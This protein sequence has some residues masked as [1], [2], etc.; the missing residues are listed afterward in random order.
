MEH[1]ILSIKR[2]FVTSFWFN[3]PRDLQRQN[4][5]HLVSAL[6]VIYDKL[7]FYPCSNSYSY[8]RSNPLLRL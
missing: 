8:S 2:D 3:L 6:Q 4:I 1:L 7:I 5:N